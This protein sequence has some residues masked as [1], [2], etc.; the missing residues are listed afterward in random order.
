MQV[1]SVPGWAS[2]TNPPSVSQQLE[3][4]T[5]LFEASVEYLQ[6]QALALM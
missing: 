3:T 1:S 5:M 2:G 6:T 4:L